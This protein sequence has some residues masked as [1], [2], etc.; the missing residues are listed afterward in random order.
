MVHAKPTRMM[1]SLAGNQFTTFAGR[2]G[3]FGVVVAGL[4]VRL[5]MDSRRCGSGESALRHPGGAEEEV[6]RRDV[7]VRDRAE[8]VSHADQQHPRW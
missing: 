5:L 4:V 2:M 3:V 7:L 8:V 1:T 6:R